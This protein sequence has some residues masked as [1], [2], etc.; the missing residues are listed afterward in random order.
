MQKKINLNANEQVNGKKKNKKMLLCHIH[1][2]SDDFFFFFSYLEA[3]E[4]SNL[5]TQLDEKV[6]STSE[7]K[8]LFALDMD[9]LKMQ[10]LKDT[11][12]EL[13]RAVLPLVVV[14]LLTRAG[15]LM[16]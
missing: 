12:A 8:A 7:D 3:V 14:V 5:A 4:H 10:P 9:V 2:S 11:A 15:G 6:P 13:G 16:P 1:I